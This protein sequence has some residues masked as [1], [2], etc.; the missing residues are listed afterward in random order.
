[1]LNEKEKKELELIEELCNIYD[2][3]DRI[4]A[5]AI[6]CDSGT[7]ELFGSAHKSDPNKGWINLSYKK[8]GDSEEAHQDFKFIEIIGWEYPNLEA[9]LKELHDFI[10]ELANFA[11][12]IQLSTDSKNTSRVVTQSLEGYYTM[13]NT[14]HWELSAEISVD[15]I[16]LKLGDILLMKQTFESPLEMNIISKLALRYIADWIELFGHRLGEWLE[17]NVALHDRRTALRNLEDFEY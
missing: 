10:T 9:A 15:T 14:V 1:M 8:S 7:L 12:R 3:D 11:D 13:Y 2:S 16:T 5:T 17:R 6:E 4:A